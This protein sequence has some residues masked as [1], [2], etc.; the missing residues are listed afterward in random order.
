MQNT[1]TTGG[2]DQSAASQAPQI[3]Q[4]ERRTQLSD[5]RLP[6]PGTVQQDTPTVKQSDSLSDTVR[7]TG[8]TSARVAVILGNTD[9]YQGRARQCHRR[10]HPGSHEC[11]T[12]EAQQRN[13]D[14]RNLYLEVLQLL[15]WK[16]EII[17]GEVVAD[18]DII[19]TRVGEPQLDDSAINRMVSILEVLGENKQ[20]EHPVT[21]AARNLTPEEVAAV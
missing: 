13:A 10:S 4:F 14:R 2:D 16:A 5:D 3:Q 9:K 15:G 1:R 21:K 11:K 19:F 6:Y 20:G 18:N 17:T 7:H 12:S 8:G